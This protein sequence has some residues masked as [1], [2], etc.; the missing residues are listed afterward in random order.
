MPR[1]K[2][3]K[4]KVKKQT[5]TS[6]NSSKSASTNDVGQKLPHKFNLLFNQ[7]VKMYERKLYKK[8]LKIA[9][10]ILDKY[11][12]AGDTHAMRALILDKMDKR[13]DANKSIKIALKY[14][15]RSHTAWH[16]YGMILRQRN[17]YAQAVKCF[18]V[19]LR[20]DPENVQILKDLSFLQLQQR[21][22]D[23]FAKSRQQ[24]LGIKS[25]S[26]E[27][28]LGLGIS[29]HLNGNPAM[30][31]SVLQAYRGTLGDEVKKPTYEGGEIVMYVVFEREAREF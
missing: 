22:Y 9:K 24:M 25:N 4:K 1:K 20:N 10:K 13:Q 23:R 30:A 3:G 14:A 27:N 28:W 26:K 16:V 29:H 7:V 31:L 11:P 21:Q 17:N 15:P 8:G 2:K 6:S 5:T 19:A 18:G 12:K